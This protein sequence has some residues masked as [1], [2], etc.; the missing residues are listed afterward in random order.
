MTEF[1]IGDKYIYDGGPTVEYVGNSISSSL[2]CIRDEDGNVVETLP[3]LLK[4]IQGKPNLE[5]GK[6]Y[7]FLG[8]ATDS[9]DHPEYPYTVNFGDDNPDAI[10][11][12]VI[13]KPAEE[14]DSND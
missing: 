11:G 5:I 9:D 7:W 12:K 3:K 14:V 2:P 4:P 10:T 6:K 1:K 13:F 8:E